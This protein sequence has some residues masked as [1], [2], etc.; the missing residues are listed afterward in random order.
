MIVVSD[1][2]PIMNLAV[3]DQLN[4]LEKLYQKVFIPEAVFHELLTTLPESAA[5]RVI[6][7]TL[8][9]EKRIVANQSLVDSLIL[10]LDLGEAEAIVLAMEMKSDL[11]LL[12]ERRARQVSSRLG[13]KF[14]GLLGILVEAK[15]KG[16]IGAVK[17]IIDDL[18]VKAGFWV[19]SRLYNRILR[20]VKE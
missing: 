9:L 20:E 1:T 4:L 18:M 3:I 13:L 19:G 6:P 15:Q 11:L 10:E 8:W 16:Y 14:I 2:S 7:K 17:P 12:D 5:G